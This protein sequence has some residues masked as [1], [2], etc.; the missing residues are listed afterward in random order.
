MYS[1]FI[2][3]NIVQLLLHISLGSSPKTFIHYLQFFAQLHNTFFLILWSVFLL[4]FHANP[5]TKG[6]K[7]KFSVFFGYF[8]VVDADDF[9]SVLYVGFLCQ[10][11][12]FS[13]GSFYSLFI[14]IMWVWVC[15][16][17]CEREI[18]LLYSYAFVVVVVIVVVCQP[19]H[20]ICV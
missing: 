8:V 12:E 14:N 10:I 3:L 7:K 4:L 11:H 15:V 16:C 2:L 1:G 9:V 6:K 17:V 19:T 5:T 18:F 20:Y 13:N